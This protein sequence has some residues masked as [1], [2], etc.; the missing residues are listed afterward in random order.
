MPAAY[1][2]S[3]LSV[4]F[5]MLFKYQKTLHRIRSILGI[6]LGHIHL[7]LLSLAVLEEVGGY[8]RE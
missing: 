7:V 3:A 5:F 2:V 8:L 6:R 1:H 4:V